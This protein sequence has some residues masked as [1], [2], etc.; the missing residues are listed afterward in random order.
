MA[1]TW[2]LNKLKYSR[3]LVCNFTGLSFVSNNESYNSIKAT[4]GMD[5]CKLYYDDKYVAY[6]QDD[7]YVSWQVLPPVYK[8]ITFST[9][10]T[11]DLL[12]WLQTYATK[13]Q[14]LHDQ[15]EQC[16]TDAYTAIGNKSG[17]I[18]TNKNLQNLAGAIGTI[19]TGV[20]TSDATATSA[21][22]LKD[23][24]AYVK[25]AKV[26]GTIETYDGTVGDIGFNITV[27]DFYASS[28]GRGN[29]NI[30]IAFDRVPTSTDY[31]YS[32][33]T[34]TDDYTPIVKDKTGKVVTKPLTISGVTTINVIETTTG[35]NVW[36][37]VYSGTQRL[38]DITQD[39]RS[40][41]YT[42]TQNITDMK[43]AGSFNE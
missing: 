34:Q 13:Q 10:P 2:V 23:K 40:G 12:T 19:S 20:D 39:N 17:T 43:W 35:S 38:I 8:S 5:S 27:T 14:T 28:G 22:I 21:D 29:N 18:P 4:F 37:T 26:T 1:E 41:S 30:Y 42:F 3:A 6:I 24:T 32:F 36:F 7:D 31:D 33:V 9:P 15:A 25:G 16:I 11:G